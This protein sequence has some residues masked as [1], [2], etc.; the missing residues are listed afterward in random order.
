MEG[1]YY[2]HLC[3]KESVITCIRVWDI[4]INGYCLLLLFLS[5]KCLCEV[6]GRYLYT[7][8]MCKEIE[9]KEVR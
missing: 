9:S 3:S 4:I 5:L 2:L 1:V 6:K 8:F 7:C